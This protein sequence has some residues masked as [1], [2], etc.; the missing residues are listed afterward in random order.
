LLPLL[1]LMPNLNGMW[2]TCASGTGLLLLLS[3][4][5]RV[6]I[7]RRPAA[8]LL[9]YCSATQV[10]LLLLLLLSALL[11]LSLFAA[12]A[13][14]PVLLYLPTLLLAAAC[15]TAPCRRACCRTELEVAL[16]GAGVPA[17]ALAL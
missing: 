2:L 5:T 13:L 8:T 14:E 11:V 6:I 17:A 16:L 4:P 15:F 10:L 12:R 1:L 3:P 9:Q 7:G